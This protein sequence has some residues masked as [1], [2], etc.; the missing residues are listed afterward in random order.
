MVAPGRGCFVRKARRPVSVLTAGQV[1]VN[2]FIQPLAE[3]L[4]LVAEPCPLDQSPASRELLISNGFS[5]SPD[6]SLAD[7]IMVWSGNSDPQTTGFVSYFLLDLGVGTGLRYWTVQGSAA[8]TNEDHT[9]LF[10]SNRATFI[11]SNAPRSEYQI[12]ALQYP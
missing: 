12:P 5:G 9:V 8:L 1:R 11:R 4:N 7:Q 2:R 6:P 3:G 10:R